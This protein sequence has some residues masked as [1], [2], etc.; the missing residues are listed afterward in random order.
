[1]LRSA[2]QRV[3]ACVCVCVCVAQPLGHGTHTGDREGSRQGAVLSLCGD[4]CVLRAAGACQTAP[5]QPPGAGIAASKDASSVFAVAPPGAKEM[6]A[7]CPPPPLTP[8][9]HPNRSTTHAQQQQGQEVPALLLTQTRSYFAPLS[10]DFA[11]GVA[12]PKVRA[13]SLSLRLCPTSDAAGSRGWLLIKA[14]RV[15]LVALGG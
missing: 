4:P 2:A 1:M 6:A 11:D 15:R 3:S 10:V 8:H 13:L 7:L 5:D 12:T 9:A 14:P